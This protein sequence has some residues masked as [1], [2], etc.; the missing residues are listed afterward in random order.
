MQ[1]TKLGVSV[2]ILGACIY[3]LALFGSYTPTILL[4]GY[5][6]LREENEWLKKCAVKAVAVMITISV[7]INVFELIPDVI[8]WINSIFA[9][10]GLGF[11]YSFITS[12]IG[13]FTG[14]L[15]IVKTCVL[16]LL[17]L[18]AL[19]QGTIKVPVVDKMIEKYM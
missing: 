13:V 11:G 18:T 15:S 14:G 12:V 19:N 10:I 3:F 4:A 8:F 2:G 17:G 7:A 1:K 16:L 6:L 5:V 9:T